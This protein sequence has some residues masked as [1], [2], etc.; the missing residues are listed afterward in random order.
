VD[1]VSICDKPGSDPV[2]PSPLVSIGAITVVAS[3]FSQANAR[4]LSAP[5]QSK[6]KCGAFSCVGARRQAAA[7]RFDDCP[8]DREPHAGPLGSIVQLS[9]NFAY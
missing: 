5:G 1:T 3:V 4:T 8:A 2:R 9:Y 6:T 7:M